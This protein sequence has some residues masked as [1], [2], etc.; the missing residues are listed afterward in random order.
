MRISGNHKA[1]GELE[2][3]PRRRKVSIRRPIKLQ[4]C[5]TPEDQNIIRTI[6]RTNP[7]D[8]KSWKAMGGWHR[9]PLVNR[10][11]EEEYIN[12]RG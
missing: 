6:C 12:L 11:Q 8:G 9:F 7:Q 5:F 4:K 3:R 1:D 10:S 2:S